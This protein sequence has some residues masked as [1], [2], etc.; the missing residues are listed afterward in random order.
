MNDLADFSMQIAKAYQ[1]YLIFRKKTL[2]K[3]IE[4]AQMGIALYSMSVCQTVPALNAYLFKVL[5]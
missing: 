1:A 3:I 2:K 5:L 4:L